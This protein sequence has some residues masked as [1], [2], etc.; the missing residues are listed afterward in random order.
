MQG[1]RGRVLIAGRSLQ[2]KAA[3]PF[4]TILRIHG[5]FLFVTTDK[6]MWLAVNLDSLRQVVVLRLRNITAI[7]ATGLHAFDSSNYRRDATNR[8]R[9]PLLPLQ[10]KIFNREQ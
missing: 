2:D 8:T 4:L 3:P 7:D 10:R 6:L 9:L 5:A 1:D